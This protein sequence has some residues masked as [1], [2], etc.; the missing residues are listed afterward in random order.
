MRVLSKKLLG[1]WIEREQAEKAENE[2]EKRREK[3]REEER[4]QDERRFRCS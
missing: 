1:F 2:E 3:R 4:V